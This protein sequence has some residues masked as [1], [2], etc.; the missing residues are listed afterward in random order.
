ME[1]NISIE[2]LRS[3]DEAELELFY[4]TYYPHFL[5]FTLNYVNDDVEVC[6]D[7]VQE[8]FI[9][10]WQRYSDFDDLVSLKVF[11]YRSLRNRCLNELRS[12][13][14]HGATDI[15][16]AKRLESMSTL[17][18]NVLREEVALAVR[19]AIENLPPQARRVLQLSLEGKSNKEIAEVMNVSINTIKT[20]KE[21]AY[22]SLRPQLRNIHQILL[23][24]ASL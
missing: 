16:D 22:A 24:L 20:H 1:L 12:R 13:S 15:A 4:R 23:L 9:A 14:N 21:K 11:F 17:E 8:V 2:A 3:G 18:E 19:S 7:I 10:Y 6:R 5:S